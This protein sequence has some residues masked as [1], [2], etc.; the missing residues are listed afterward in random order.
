[1]FREKCIPYQDNLAAY[2]LDALDVEEI[3]ALESHLA[4]CL[5]CPTELAGYREIAEGLLHSILLTAPPARLRRKLA[6][7]L[8]S[9]Q[10]RISGLLPRILNHLPLGQFA[11]TA[12]LVI[13]LSLNIFSAL[14]IRDLQRQQRA[15]VQRL[16]DER[17]A[18]VMLA[19][20]GTQ[21]LEVSADVQSL[22]G[23][24]LVH[25][26]MTTAVL[27]LQNLP[28][29]AAGQTYQ[30]W[31]VD[32]N[33]NRMSGGLFISSEGQ[34]YTTASIQAS[35]PIGQYIAIGVTIEPAGGSDQPTGERV[36]VVNL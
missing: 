28:R 32:A 4:T 18:L 31:L 27:V 29:L 9:V 25:K 3:N 24:V 6:N 34:D 26:D 35:D 12:L 22:T 33:G 23:S 8:P 10:D 13:L 14:Q 15:L 36:L 21:A 19:Y 17:V 11:V 2:S 20:P 5:D 16:S 1:M 30:I 7:Q